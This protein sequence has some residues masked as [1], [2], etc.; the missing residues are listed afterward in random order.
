MAALQ[1]PS[2]DE[3]TVA[4]LIIQLY[5]Y[6]VMMERYRLDG[7]KLKKA[8]VRRGFAS[9]LDFAR[10]HG[11]NRATLHNYLKGRGPLPDS[12]YKICE[13]LETD[14]L[15]LL[16]PVAGTK[17]LADAEELTHILRALP[18]QDDL[19]A[20]GLLGSRAKGT[21][22]KYSDWDLGVTRGNAGLTTKDFLKY[23]HLVSD[24]ADDLPRGI[25][26]VNLDAAPAW[27]LS[28]VDYE[29]LFL[30]GNPISWSHFMGVLHGTQKAA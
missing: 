27:F 10:A 3:Q 5:I 13:F 20:I 17:K 22:K 28:G 7:P 9:V 21:A 29:P 23:K 4:Y 2:G 6:T 14:A 24:L 25:D 18:R 11:I 15:E 16:S 26:L 1:G 8:L 12:Y 19:L 30:A